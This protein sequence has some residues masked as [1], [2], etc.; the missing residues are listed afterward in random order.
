MGQSLSSSAAPPPHTHTLTL[1][2]PQLLQLL[3]HLRGHSG[4]EAVLECVRG[5]RPPQGALGVL[6]HLQMVGGGDL[7][8]LGVRAQNSRPPAQSQ[9]PGG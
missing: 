7:S 9:T 4:R 6:C 5:A 8:A 2:E 3:L 1:L